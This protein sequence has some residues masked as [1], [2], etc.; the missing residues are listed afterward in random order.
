MREEAFYTKIISRLEKDLECL[1]KGYKAAWSH[2]KSLPSMIEEIESKL[3]GKT[4]FRNDH[5]PR[6]KIDILMG[7]KSARTDKIAL[8]LF[9]VKLSNNLALKDF[10]QLAGYLQVAKKIQAG[11]LLLIRK[12]AH[13]SGLSNDFSDILHVNNLP[14]WWQTVLKISRKTTSYYFK[15]GVC[16]YTQNDG[17]DWYPT[18]RLGGF[19]NYDDFVRFIVKELR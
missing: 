19:G 18:E 10:S 6:L 7:I 4:L 11:I 3:K 16:L 13:T 17:I 8:T 14:M 12:S 5:V 1:P 9:E 2:N 15:T